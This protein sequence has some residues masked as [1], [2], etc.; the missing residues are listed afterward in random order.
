M[1]QALE[2]L[3]AVESLRQEVADLLA[4]LHEQAGRYADLVRVLSVKLEAAATPSDKVLVWTRVAQIRED[5]LTDL[6]GAFEA[7]SQAVEADPTDPA[8]RAQLARIADAQGLHA[9]YADVLEQILKKL[10]D[11]LP[12]RA[13]LLGRLAA[14]YDESLNDPA[15]AEQ[16]YRRWLDVDRDDPAIA[17]PAAQALERILAARERHADLVDVLRIQARFAETAERRVE[18]LR[19]VAEIQESF[20]S[21]GAAALATVEEI[22][23]VAPQDLDNLR[24]LERLYHQAGQWP[25]LVNVL[26]RRSTLAADPQDR[27]SIAYRIAELLEE[28]LADRDE[29]IG[30]GLPGNPGRGAGEVPAVRALLRRSRRRRSGPTCSTPSVGCSSWCPSRPSRCRCCARWATCSV[31]GRGTSRRRPNRIARRWSGTARAPR[32]ARPWSL[33]RSRTSSSP[34][35]ASWPGS[36]RAGGQFRPAA[37]DAG[38][39]DDRGRGRRSPGRRAAAGGR[40]AEVALSDARR[41]FG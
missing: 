3:L 20:L 38:H 12:L 35:P 16:A 1:L 40:E 10:G 17:I 37:G 2:R 27:R 5:A 6:D 14:L 31:S 26:R 36:Q 13:E 7:Y 24:A 18:L 15:K 8:P 9:L 32:P 28:K 19:R 22:D 4:P 39:R 25:K 34:R 41:S 11:D 33:R 21:D 23:E 30:G 29:A